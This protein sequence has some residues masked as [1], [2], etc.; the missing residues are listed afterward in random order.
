MTALSPALTRLMELNLRFIMA[1]A[2]C[3]D[4]F[5][6]IFAVLQVI[7]PLFDLCHSEHLYLNPTPVGLQSY[8]LLFER[9]GGSTTP[10]IKTYLGTNLTQFFALEGVGDQNTIGYF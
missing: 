2:A 6:P 3:Q 4:F 5:L 1:L 7:Y 8:Q 10:S 9:G